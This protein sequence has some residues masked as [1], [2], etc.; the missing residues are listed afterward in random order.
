M[1]ALDEAAGAQTLAAVPVQQPRQLRRVFVEG[2]GLEHEPAVD[3]L[4]MLEVQR[5]FLRRGEFFGLHRVDGP[6]DDA[7][8]DHGAG[9]HADDRLG[10]VDG[11][12][13]VAAGGAADRVHARL[14]PE[15]DVVEFCRKINVLPLL[16]VLRM[17]PHQE[18]RRA[19]PL[20]AAARGS[21]RSTG[22]RIP[23]PPAR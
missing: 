19:Q 3:V 18:A 4:Q 7:G 17:R 22:A 12:E 10:V 2:R 16:P 1:N 13:V 8:L 5:A 9:I 6:A 14:R 21:R 11:V 15:R 20:I 23:L